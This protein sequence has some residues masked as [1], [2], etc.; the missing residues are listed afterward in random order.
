MG[1]IE[2]RY[3]KLSIQSCMKIQTNGT[4]NTIDK[5]TSFTYSLDSKTKIP[6]SVDPNAFRIPISF[7]LC[8]AVYAESPNNP[9]QPTV[10]ASAANVVNNFPKV[11][12]FSYWRLKKS[13]R[14]KN[15]HG[16]PGNAFSQACLTCAALPERFLVAIR[17]E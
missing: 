9:R 17:T 16:F 12:S 3:G 14:K 2:V 7:V 11:R 8:A 4:A 5:K 15:S 6:R 1:D 13:S 10:I